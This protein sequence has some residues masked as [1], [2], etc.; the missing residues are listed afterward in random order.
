MAQPTTDHVVAALAIHGPATKE[1]IAYAMGVSPE[2]ALQAIRAA[3]RSKPALIRK[4]QVDT[5]ANFITWTLDEAG[6]QRA[7]E[8]E[9]DDD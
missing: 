9:A 2:A 7:A 1:E 3:A 8:L 6:E 5:V 4:G